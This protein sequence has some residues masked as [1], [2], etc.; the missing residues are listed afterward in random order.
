M[1]TEV[2]G[3]I[4]RGRPN[5]RWLDSVGADVREKGLLREDIIHRPQI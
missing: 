4:R 1:G 2:Q 5:W 3:K